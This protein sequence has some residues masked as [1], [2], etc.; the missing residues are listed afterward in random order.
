MNTKRDAFALL[1]ALDD[2]NALHLSTTLCGAHRRWVIDEVK[3]RLHAGEACRLVSTQVIEAGVD[4][5]FPLVLRAVAPLDAIIQAAGRCNREGRLARGRVI[6]FQP[7]DGGYPSKPYKA[8]ADITL[9]LLAR[10]D[11]DPDDPAAAREYFQ[12]LFR[13]FEVDREQIQGLRA[14]FDY[15][16]VA[17]LFRLIDDDTESV[18]VRYGSDEER[19]EVV[20]RCEQLRR[21]PSD[22]R[23]LLR[24]LQPYLV[25]LYLHHAERYRNQGLIV[26]LTPGVG[27]WLGSYHPVRG[28]TGTGPDVDALVF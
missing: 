5:D 9:A 23:R 3:R 16:R 26:P 21:D 6:V 20:K 1:D 15:P 19:R 25:S 13:T 24:Q 17:E 11:L 28:L 18:V 27:E 10:G 12:Q 7:T 22:A 2:P 14:A 8:A 4:L